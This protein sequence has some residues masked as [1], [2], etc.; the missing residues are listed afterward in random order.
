MRTVPKNV[1]LVGMND[2]DYA[3]LLPV[4][5]TTI[6]QPRGEIGQA[7]VAVV[8]ERIKTPQMVPRQILLDCR[9]VVRESSV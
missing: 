9:L 4:P 8:I 2:V 7:A 1:R 5:L 3:A 6:H